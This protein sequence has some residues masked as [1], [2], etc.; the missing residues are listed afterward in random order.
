[1]GTSRKSKEDLNLPQASWIEPKWFRIQEISSIKISTFRLRMV[2]IHS[3]LLRTKRDLR[4]HCQKTGQIQESKGVL[5]QRKAKKTKMDLMR[6]TSMHT[7][8]GSGKSYNRNFHGIRH[9]KS[10]RKDLKYGAGLT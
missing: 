5:Q 4:A 1:L 10:I 9:L 6:S 2:P 3:L 8:K 7:M